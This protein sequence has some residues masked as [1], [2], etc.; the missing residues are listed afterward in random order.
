MK[1]SIAYNVTL[2]R[3]STALSKPLYRCTNPY[4]QHDGDGFHFYNCGK[5]DYCNYVRSVNLSQRVKDEMKLRKYAIFITL[6]YDNEHVPAL[7]RSSENSKWYHLNRTKRNSD[8]TLCTPIV[9]YS[10]MVGMHE[11]MSRGQKIPDVY[12]VLWQQDVIDFK[13]RLLQRIYRRF[14]QHEEGTSEFKAAKKK[15]EVRF[16]ISGEYGETFLRPHYHGV[17]WTDNEEVANYLVGTT[18]RFVKRTN[19]GYVQQS[20]GNLSACWKM[21]DSSNL[22]VQP[23]STNNNTASYVA[24][25]PP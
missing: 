18:K 5:C 9:H 12:G 17:L 8:G 20:Y 25:Y 24:S 13:K 3:N 14:I 16:F 15:Y 19:G 23:L 11:L 1:H 22:N 10:D 21:C 2:Q 4:V 6:T 7:S